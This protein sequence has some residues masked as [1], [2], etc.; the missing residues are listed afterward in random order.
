VAKRYGAKRTP[1]VFLLDRDRKLRY[2]GRI[3]DSRDPAK[4]TRRDLQCAVADLL[5][6][7]EVEVLE[8][9]PVG[10]AIVW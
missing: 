3:A 2:R 10:C 6:P 9:E 7:K 5:A 4:V 8:T 1:H